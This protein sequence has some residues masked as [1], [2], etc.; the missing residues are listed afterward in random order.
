MKGQPPL[1]LDS[2]I[3]LRPE[4]TG[5]LSNKDDPQNDTIWY[6]SDERGQEQQLRPSAY[7]ARD[8]KMNGQGGSVLPAE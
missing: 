7:V 4:L 3:P 1:L 8:L 6:L 5:L 2:G